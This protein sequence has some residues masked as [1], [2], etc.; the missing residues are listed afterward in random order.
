MGVIKKQAKKA[1]HT[2]ANKTLQLYKDSSLAVDPSLRPFHARNSSFSELP[3][4]NKL[5]PALKVMASC[6]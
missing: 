6:A 3:S 5:G 1:T 2:I 4:T